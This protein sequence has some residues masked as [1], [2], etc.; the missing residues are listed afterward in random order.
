ML[1]KEEKAWREVR[2]NQ[3][4][5]W[6]ENCPYEDF[7]DD[8]KIWSI[9][10]A[11]KEPERQE[12]LEIIEKAKE[13]AYTGA[14]LAPEEVAAL[15]NTKDPDLWEAIFEAATWIKNTVYGSRIVLFSPLYISSPC[16]NNCAY[17]GF[18]QSNEAVKKKTLTMEELEDEI[19]VLTGMGQKRLIVVYGEHPVSDVKFMCET[20]EKIYSLKFGKGEIRRVNVNAPPLFKEE[21]EEIK[22][23]GIGTYQVFQE[24]YHHET[25]RRMHPKGT[26]KG[27]YKWRLFAL[28]RALEADIDDVAIGVL[29]G[30]YDW[31][32]ELLGLLYHAYSLEKEF[33]VGTHTISYPRLEPAVN[34]PITTKSSYLVSDEDFKKIVAIIRLMCPYTGS[35]LTAREPA[36][37]RQEVL[38]KCGV[39]QMD[40]GTRIAVGGYAEMEKEHIPEKQQ[41]MIQDT[42]S[43]D[44]FILDLCREGYLPSFCTA[45][46]RE[47]RTGDN[48]MPLAKHATVKN[49]CIANGIL[50]FKEYLL[51]YA[52][53]EVKELGEKVI[54]PEYL[55]WLEDN[56]PRAAE[57]VKELLK[58][59]EK[60]ERDCHL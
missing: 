53:P 2:L 21:Y 27:E 17:C 26:L 5:K 11:K 51:D 59:E 7:I 14:M 22:T 32:F 8:E 47:G 31:R 57:R 42:R 19:R 28:H 15:A 40:A 38:K 10:E 30:L 24:T 18:R 50:T 39:S 9:I 25:Y 36:S 12:I 4:L 43:L 29:L 58:R 46:Y 60:G 37:L 20:I 16:V 1:T 33:G 45:C 34:T 13:N 54:I 56:I 55:K 41:F 52:S 23:V 3:I 48:F 35:I 6:E 44:E 49:F